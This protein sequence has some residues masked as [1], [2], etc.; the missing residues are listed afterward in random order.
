MRRFHGTA[1]LSRLRRHAWFN[2]PAGRCTPPR[3]RP[4]GGWHWGRCVQLSFVR[5][6]KF[7]PAAPSGGIPARASVAKI[8][9]AVGAVHRPGLLAEGDFA[10]PDGDVDIAGA[11]DDSIGSHHDRLLVG[12]VAVG[13]EQHRHCLLL[14]AGQD[15]RQRRDHAPRAPE[16]RRARE[17]C[18]RRVGCIDAGGGRDNEGAGEASLDL[19]G[20]D[21]KAF[22]G[23]QAFS[24]PPEAGATLTIADPRLSASPATAASHQCETQSYREHDETP[25]RASP[26]W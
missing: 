11:T 8:S 22:C 13:G 26:A 4:S 24:P 7:D 21:L 23:I 2:S 17:L 1:V 14:G 19:L 18:G 25:E 12:N 16:R 15:R 5:L 6:S 20:S 10:V 3:C 9:L